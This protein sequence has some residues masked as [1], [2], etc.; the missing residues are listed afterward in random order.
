MVC[1]PL[2][3][4]LRPPA[5]G[6]V[7]EPRPLQA[8]HV[9]WSFWNEFCVSCRPYMYTAYAFAAFGGP[10]VLAKL[11]AFQYPVHSAAVVLVLLISLA[12]TGLHLT[13]AHNVVRWAR[14]R[15]DMGLDG[16][17]YPWEVW[18]G[19][20]NYNPAYSIPNAQSAPASS[21]EPVSSPDVAPGSCGGATSATGREARAAASLHRR[22]CICLLMLTLWQCSHRVFTNLAAWAALPCLKPDASRNCC[23]RRGR[24]HG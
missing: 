15:S 9:H 18:P 21:P 3:T 10:F 4:F 24:R 17:G 6:S 7:S 13:A 11:L 12:F 5:K 22:P 19:P 14:H 20:M 2:V 8:V 1:A 23:C 16:F